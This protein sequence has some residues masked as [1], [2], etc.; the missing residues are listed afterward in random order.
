[1]IDESTLDFIRK[2]ADKDI[3]TLALQAS[4]Y[5]DVDMR[6]AATQIEG[7]HIATNKL[8]SWAAVEG[9]IYPPRLSMEQCSSEATARYKASLTQGK[10]LTDLTGGFGIDCSYM[11]EHFES[12]TYV[13]RNSELCDIALHNFA[14]LCKPIQVINGQSEEV[15]K[16]LAKQDWI[17]IDPARRSKSGA[18][19][20]ALS[21][22]E[23][24]VC[25]MEDL[26]L[27][28]AE[29]VMIKCS[30]ML[31]ISQAIRDL[32]SVSEVHVVSVNNECKELLFILGN[33]Q[34]EEITIHTINFRNDHTQTF[35]YTVTDETKA[36][37]D[38]TASVGRYLY[39]PNSSMMKA[40]C[41][42]LPAARWKLKKLHNNTHLYTSDILVKE[43]PGRIFEVESI[44]GFGKNELK[45]LSSRLKKANIAVRNFPERPE[46][47][48]KRLKL[49]D[50]GDIYLF[51]TTLDNER[52]VIIQCRKA[53][54]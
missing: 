1:M 44:D 29:R 48:R 39:E 54:V 2:H 23:P 53:S 52:H 37:C 49:S 34:R 33:S 6:V 9:V 7:R 8:P 18:K 32:H 25:Q 28:K 51:A 47:L 14:L 15:L 3:R 22:C 50:G 12:T 21:D 42:R 35:S 27:E 16:S 46:A 10:L 43:F 13:E 45:Q 26:L 4:R 36:T 17:F 19:V 5:P 31:D 11:S 30:P 40:G 41:F 38:Y 20:A 24:D